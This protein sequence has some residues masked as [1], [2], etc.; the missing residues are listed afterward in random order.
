MKNLNLI[1]L[2]LA[3]F[4]VQPS[5]AQTPHLTLSAQYPAA[6]ETVTLIYDPAGTA[7]DGKKGITGMVYFMDHKDYPVADINLKAD[8]Q[9]QKGDFTIPGTATSFYI[10]LSSDQTVDNN[11]DKGYVYLVYKDD[12]PVPGAYASE[13]YM[14]ASGM[15]TNFAKIKKDF[16]A[17]ME[18][19]K[20]EFELHPESLKDYKAN[21][22]MLMAR[23]PDYRQTALQKV[24]DLET[25]SDEKDLELAATLLNNMKQSK[26]SD[27]LKAI[28]RTKF[29]NGDLVKNEA[30][31]AFFK[32][33]DPAKKDSLYRAYIQRYPE[34]P[35]E[36]NSTQSYMR[37]Q[38]AAAYFEK[39]DFDNFNRVEKEI[40]NR[41]DLAM[42]FNN[43]TYEWAKQGQHLDEA[44]KYSKESLE[45][46]AEKIKHPD[47]APYR[48]PSQTKKDEE[49]T[50][51][52]FADTYALILYRKNDFKEALKYEQPVID[53]QTA[54]DPETN[55]HYVE[56]LTGAGDYRKALT[57]G[58]KAIATGKGT[59][60]VT[61]ELKK[62][63]IRQK[64]SE[65][66]FDEYLAALKNEAANHTR[67]ELAKTMI[68]QPAPSFALKDIDGQ[69]V[70]LAD[71]KGKIVIVDFWATWCGPCKASFPG[72]QMAVNKYKDDPNVKFLFVDCWETDENYAVLVKKFIADNQYSF[73]VLL[74]EK[75]SD[76]RQS[77]V[78][79]SF[80][81]LG[82][83]TKFIIDKTGNI[84]FK[85]IGYSGAPEQLVSEVTAMID[86][87]NDPPTVSAAPSSAG[88]RSGSNK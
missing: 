39:A 3:L 53:H 59:D 40:K 78:V 9:T 77:K 63:Y 28:I 29:P 49:Y 20:K 43:T 71:L 73:H 16:P 35:T 48:S 51:D 12:Q 57:Y 83:P 19:F 5:L 15:G 44:K 31:T 50:Y 79:G 70:S 11:N 69:T 38:L 67:E 24:A 62:I 68:N 65:K 32:E 88:N 60:V 75:G 23:S 6:G 17:G 81:V 82:I 85:Y 76:G 72:M 22:Y 10:K 25:S 80:D 21:Y 87:A 2:S 34:D 42:T 47:P 4:A 36:K 1:G 37:V 55:E 18:L 30:S 66:G 8:G 41:A 45:L 86:M 27:S 58:E 26:S 56:I 46:V 14:L 33:K 64:G 7:L 74:D 54:F 52:L 61:G 84:R 13:G